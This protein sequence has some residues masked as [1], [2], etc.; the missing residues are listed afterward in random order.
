MDAD[1][2]VAGGGLCGLT[3]ARDL[4]GHGLD[5]LVLEARD[6]LGG[7]TWTKRAAMAGL[8]LELGGM[9]VD[10]R[11]RAV[12]SE[13]ERYSLSVAGPSRPSVFRWLQAGELRDGLPPVPID[14]LPD[15]ERAWL[16]LASAAARVDPRRPLADQ[17]LDDLDVSFPRFLDP[18]ALGPATSDLLEA[19]LGEHQSGDWHHASALGV[20]RAIAV[21][22]GVANFLLAATFASELEDGTVALVDALVEDGDFDIA[23][24]RPVECVE[25]SAGGVRAITAGADYT[26]ELLVCALPLNM[27]DRVDWRPALDSGRAAAAARGHVGSGHKTWALAGGVPD[28]LLAYGPGPEIQLVAAERRVGDQVLL[29][30]FGA[31]P[32]DAEDPTAVQAALASLLP[33]AEVTQSLRPRLE[34]RPLGAR[35]VG[36]ACGWLG[37]G[38]GGVPGR[39]RAGGVRIR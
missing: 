37:C 7:R 30:C 5:V 38:A 36:R 34:R 27:V 9:Y 1:V 22:G 33:E 35:H 12:W 29:V 14:E 16:W 3:A 23:L 20:L 17:R 28:G 18:L 19:V 15:L 25:R 2:I 21:S 26:A 32:I 39:G 10:R 11:Q 8:D 6:R 31:G 24:D 4:S 13:I